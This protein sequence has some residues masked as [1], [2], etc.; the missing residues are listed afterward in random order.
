[1]FDDSADGSGWEVCRLVAEVYR[2]GRYQL[3]KKNPNYLF[4]K[5]KN[6]EE[7]D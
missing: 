3:I 6:I 5:L 2:A 7:I 4:K 1:L